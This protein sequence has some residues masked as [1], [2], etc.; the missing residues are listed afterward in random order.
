M[1]V[2]YLARDRERGADVALKTLRR[3]DAPTLLHFKREFR[4]LAGISHPNLVS[5]Y[6]LFHVGDQWFFT[7]ELTE[8]V[9]FLEWVRSASVARAAEELEATIAEGHDDQTIDQALETI[10]ADEGV[11]AAS[12]PNTGVDLERLRLALRQLVSG[13]HALHRAGRIHRDIKPSNVRVLPSGRVVVLDFGLVAE[14]EKGEEHVS[15][16]DRIVGTAAYMSPEQAAGGTVT[17]A[18]DWYAVGSMLYEALTG[19][20]PFSGPVMDVLIDKAKKDGPRPRLRDASIPS[21]LDALTTSLLRRDPKARPSASQLLVATGADERR[22]LHFR[23]RANAQRVLVGRDAELRVLRQAFASTDERRAATVWVRGEAGVGKSALVANFVETLN[24]VGNAVV[25]RGACHEHEAVRYRAFDSMVDALARFL[26][27]LHEDDVADIL[28]V[29]VPPLVRLFP[30]LRIVPTIEERMSDDGGEDVEPHELRLRAFRAL[31]SLLASLARRVPVVVWIDD[32]QWGDPDSAPLFFELLGPPDPPHILVI[33]SYRSEPDQRGPLVEAL[34][35]LPAGELAVEAIDLDPLGNTNARRLVERLLEDTSNDLIGI[36]DRIVEESEGSPYFIVEL[37]RHVEDDAPT[38]RAAVQQGLTLDEV[39]LARFERLPRAAQELLEAV[40]LAVRPLTHQVASEATGVEGRTALVL[41]LLE[42]GSFVRTTIDADGVE[43][44]TPYH[45]RIRDVVVDRLTPAARTLLH[46]RLAA[47][48]EKHHPDDVEALALHYDGAEEPRLAAQFAERAAKTASDGL[49]FD[50]AAELYALAARLDPKPSIPLRRLR[51]D[52][53]ADAGRGQEAAEE[54]LSLA[55]DLPG[56]LAL[57]MR[58]RAAEQLLRTG[59]VDRGLEA[60]THVLDDIGLSLSR[61]PRRALASL[62]RSRMAVRLRGLRFERV[63]AE[64]VAPARLERVD[65][66]WSVATGLGMVD[67]TL[68]TDFQSRHLVEALEVGEPYR[69]ARALAMEAC[70]S[71]TGG[72]GTR[73]RT[74]KVVALASQL[75]DEL[76]DP[77]AL[78]L[79]EMAK[80]A[81]AFL[82]GR[83]R[84]GRRLSEGAERI[85]RERC[86]GVQWEIA[87]AQVFHVLSMAFLGEFGALEVFVR[88]NIRETRA[89]GDRYATANLESGAANLAYLVRD[90]VAG[91]N[92]AL[93]QTRGHLPEGGFTIP[94]FYEL[95]ARINVLLYEGRIAEAYAAVNEVRK[96]AERAVVL[97][98]QYLAVDV[99]FAFARAALAAATIAAAPEPYLQDAERQ[100]TLLEREAATWV[101]PLAMSI[102]AGVLAARG[103]RA[104]ASA[105]YRA[106]AVA[107]AEHDLGHIAAVAKWRADGSIPEA[108]S[109]AEGSPRDPTGLAALREQGVSRPERLAFVF[110]PAAS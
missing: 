44:I 51:A 103:K 82:E 56:P 8:G 96:L 24:T 91:A 78:G 34:E 17:P 83:F 22:A 69:V 94:H 80:G 88:R 79:A 6:E 95:V 53:L 71:A 30:V 59:H 99:R 45:P 102:R 50:R 105:A 73:R 54:F 74:S 52:A 16:S 100:A 19:A 108:G 49:A 33:G 40:A 58:R 42:S 62:V 66:L 9:S 39:L 110:G 36:A 98:I 28:P 21:D 2:V 72:V 5:L 23:E 3:I 89:R 48:I 29:D 14:L 97:R 57:Q 32:L 92:R 27:P 70:Y 65:I 61:S 55:R 75:A 4:A 87:T 35:A 77:H 11:V 85:L 84:D 76:D 10:R 101:R 1:G 26:E 93:E 46:A 81:A 31:R 41:R 60:L 20:R 18:S 47:A 64:D 38:V 7:M 13:V 86:R 15:T 106:T 63:R 12:R 43:R 90:D 104:E 107:A 25:L 67:S 68:G 109:A 37:L